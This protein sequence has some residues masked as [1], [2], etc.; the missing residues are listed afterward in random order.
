MRPRT[1][2]K[3]LHTLLFLFAVCNVLSC[4]NPFA[5][6]L[7]DGSLIGEVITPQA[8]PEEALTNFRLAYM[9][10]DS[11]LYADVIDSAF[12]FQYFDPDQSLF[13]SWTREVDLLTTGRLLRTFDIINLE[14]F[15]VGDSLCNENNAV[16]TKGFRLD[17]SSGDFGFSAAGFAIFTFRL[18]PRDRKWRIVR[19]VDQSS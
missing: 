7:D 5:P 10:R 12:V 2:T 18:N 3:I 6:R 1:Q 9:L 16:C 13:V 15:A 19:W 17:L 8:T 4:V 14:W 11:L